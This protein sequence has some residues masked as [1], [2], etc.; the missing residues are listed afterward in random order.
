MIRSTKQNEYAGPDPLI[1]IVAAERQPSW[2]GRNG[3]PALILLLAVL[4]AYQPL[5]RAGYLWDDDELLTA[6]PCVVGPLGLK[7]V[8]TTRAADICPLTITTFWL[9]Y[10]V[11][12]LA[13]L[14]YHLV[15]VLLHAACAILLWQVL[16]RLQVP[17]AW[18]GAALWAL[19]PVQVESV[20]WI[21]EMKNTQSGVFYLLAILFY[22]R[23]PGSGALTIVCAALAMAS[24]S[25]TAVLPAVLC[26]LA[27][28]MEG[29]WRWRRRLMEIG[30]I[31]LLSIGAA[32]LSVWNQTLRP[33]ADAGFAVTPGWPQRL[34]I[35]GDAVWFYLGKLAWPHPLMAVYPRWE[36]GNV[37]WPGFLPLLAVMAVLLALW[38]KRRVWGRGWLLA[39]VYLLVALLPVLGLV[40]IS[41]FRYSFVADHFAYLASM[42]PLSLAGAGVARLTGGFIPAIKLRRTAAIAGALLLLALGTESWSRARVYENQETL[43]TDTL[44][45]NPYCWVGYGNLGNVLAGKG[46]LDAAIVLYRQALKVGPNDAKTHDNLGSVFL[47]KGQVDNAISEYREAMEINPRGAEAYYDLGNV[48]LQ[49]GQLDKAIF[50]FQ[51]ALKLSANYVA[52]YSNLGA[53]LNLK[54]QADDAIRQYEKALQIDP[55]NIRDLNN[56]GNIFLQ[57]GDVEEAT[58]QYQKALRID[59]S[60]AYTYRNVANMLSRR[61]HLDD[62]IVEYQEALKIDPA[63]AESHNNLGSA[64]FQKGLLDEAIAQYRQ[65]LR[66]EPGYAVAHRN[67]G[68]VLA[69]NGRLDEAIAQFREAIHL[70]A[71]YDDAKNDLATVQAMV[72]QGAKTN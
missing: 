59:P 53:A 55:G 62:A 51:S 63:N 13:P 29:R 1:P 66:I 72:R 68:L 9:E 71:D 39:F 34:V 3:V 36:I 31:F 30:P 61:G 12:G 70:K 60:D 14:P 15:N 43:W 27:W 46:R 2:F 41:F 69:R 57:K 33:A 32:V 11:W 58:A 47:R 40:E 45:K 35:A 23:S 25:S 42:G 44:A 56:L 10:E 18:L 52:A 64:F 17:G 6:N 37:T 22:L 4:L 48:F 26:L 50:Q 49:E 8:W 38:L 21:T 19:H 20:A 24:K 5:W 28:W 54:G 65:A 16:R 67:L 7:E